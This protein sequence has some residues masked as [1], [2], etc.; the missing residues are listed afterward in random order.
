MWYR[1][2]LSKR[3]DYR[4]DRMLRRSWINLLM[5]LER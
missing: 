2:Q 1:S 3:R 4:F 5:R